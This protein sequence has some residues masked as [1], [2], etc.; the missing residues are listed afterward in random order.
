MV[1]IYD[2]IAF[3]IFKI[4]ILESML[5]RL[6]CLLNSDGFT[7]VKGRKTQLQSAIYVRKA[8]LSG[9]LRA[10]PIFELRVG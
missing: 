6:Q 8:S 4:M 1:D 3:I 2:L 10:A 9:A 5:H 7:P